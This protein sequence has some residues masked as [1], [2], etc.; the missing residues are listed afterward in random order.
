MRWPLNNNVMRAKFVLRDLEAN[1]RSV[2]SGYI[3]YAIHPQSN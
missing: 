2:Q 1:N 3:T